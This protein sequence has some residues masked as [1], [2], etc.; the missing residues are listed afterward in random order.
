MI[1]PNSA[2]VRSNVV[3]VTLG[4][5]LLRLRC[6]VRVVD[7]SDRKQVREVLEQAAGACTWRVTGLD[8]VILLDE[9]G[10]SSVNREVSVWID[11]PLEVQRARSRLN[12]AIW[13]ALKEARI[14]IAYPQLDV[15]LDPP[16]VSRNRA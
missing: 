5:S 14:T 12:E 4:D 8:P 2:L 11:S 10:N 15:H 1:L 3:N 16:A 7:T 13:F 9:F 6:P